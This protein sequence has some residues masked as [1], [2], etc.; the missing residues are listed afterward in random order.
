MSCLFD[1]DANYTKFDSRRDWLVARRDYTGSSDTA[2]ILGVSNWQS[3]YSVWWNKTTTEEPENR[4]DEILEWGHRLETPLAEKLSETLGKLDDPGD[5]CLFVSREHPWLACTP[6]RLLYRNGI[7]EAVIELKTA[8]FAQGRI[9]GERVPEAYMVQVQHQMLVLGVKEA[10]IAVLVDG[11]QFAYHPVIA[12]ERMQKLIVR[13]TKDF[14]HQYV[15]T[16]NA[17]PP[18]YSDATRQALAARYPHSNPGTVDIDDDKIGARY[19]KLCR[20]ASSIDKRKQA[21]QNQVKDAIGPNEVAVLPDMS[22]FSWKESKN[23][24]RTFRR[25]E[26]VYDDER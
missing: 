9:W 6:D 17:P 3:P 10:H 12:H 24:R 8:H 21:I 4:T 7:L 14:W 26:R 2:A 13:K 1:I 5:F 11:Y 20:V 18:D 16:G 23:G 15:L 22:G 25:I 19:D